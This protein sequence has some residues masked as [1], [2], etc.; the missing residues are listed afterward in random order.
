MRRLVQTTHAVAM[1]WWR[2]PRSELD[3]TR[4]RDNGFLAWIAL[5]TESHR[6]AYL[7]FSLSLSLSLSL[8]A[9]PSV[10]ILLIR[11]DTCFCCWW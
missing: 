9:F 4:P 7:Y 11:A 2:V 3:P 8:S 1:Q 5:G 10:L 6:L